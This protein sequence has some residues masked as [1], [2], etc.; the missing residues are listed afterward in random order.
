MKKGTGYFL[1]LKLISNYYKNMLIYSPYKKVACPLF[2]LLLLSP[3]TTF[4][5]EPNDALPNFARPLSV[6]EE[7]RIHHLRKIMKKRAREVLAED[8]KKIKA[9]MDE[10]LK[11]YRRNFF[12]KA[13]DEFEKILQ[14]FPYH[15]ESQSYMDNIRNQMVVVTERTI[16]PDAVKLAYARGWLFYEERE[17]V[18][19]MRE[20]KRALT[21]DPNQ[22]EV[23][24]YLRKAQFMLDEEERLKT[25]QRLR[26]HQAK[27]EVQLNHLFGIALEKYRARQYPA[28]IR[29]FEKVIELAKKENIPTAGEWVAKTQDQINI[30]LAELK[31]ELERVPKPPPPKPKP[32]PVITEAA[33]KQ[34]DQYYSEG[35]SRYAAGDLQEAQ[36]LMELALR[37]NPKHERA[38]KAL[39]KIKLELKGK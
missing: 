32:E 12:L 10:A 21:L 16:A 4:A 1:L 18:N 3:I 28:A 20:W 31:R 19:A 25:E 2:F 27:I 36:R 17:I 15:K 9:M 6:A 38:A 22:S 5:S 8:R 13:K 26:A 30:V 11:F 24:E 23:E 37:S 29:E 33:K 39:E 34:A 7:K 14:D 35:L